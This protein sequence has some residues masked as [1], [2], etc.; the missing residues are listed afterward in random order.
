MTAANN[1]ILAKGIPGFEKGSNGTA[2]INGI[3]YTW[4]HHQD[5]KT[6][7]LIPSSFHNNVTGFRHTGG[8]KIIS[9]GLQGLFD[10]PVSPNI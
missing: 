9:K 4:H 3:S 8:A 10:A 7:I 6:M 5:G 2:L 1:A